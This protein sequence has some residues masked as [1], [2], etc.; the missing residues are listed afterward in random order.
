MDDQNYDNEPNTG[1]TAGASFTMHGN[2]RVFA[3]AIMM[4]NRV[5][6]ELYLEPNEEGL[7][8]R[9]LNSSKS[10]YATF[11][12]SSTFFISCDLRS[13]KNSDYNLCRISMKVCC[14]IALIIGTTSWHTDFIFRI[15]L[16]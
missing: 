16:S 9:A 1:I 8:L 2:F 3:R 11:L 13:I 5:G 14:C 10:A 6:E 7:A 15:S 4:L 12:F